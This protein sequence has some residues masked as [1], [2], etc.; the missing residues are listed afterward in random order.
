[1][2]NIFILGANGFIGSHLL[3]SLLKNTDHKI[4]TFDMGDH[5]IEGNLDHPNLTFKQGNI[6]DHKDWM[7]DQ[8]KAC[9]IVLPLIAIANPELYVKNPL[10]VF[11]LDFE[12]NLE[13]VKLCVEHKKRLIFPSTSEV[14]GMCQDE[15]FDEESSNLVLGPI[16]KQRWIYSCSKQMLDRVIYAHGIHSDLN[17][18]IF[19]PFNWVGPRLD[20]IDPEKASYARV[21]TQFISNIYYKGSLTLVDGGLQKRAFIDV[22]DAID[23][24]VRIIDNPEK[25][26]KEI[27]N[28]GYPSN[29]YSIKDLSDFVLEAMKNHDIFRDKVAA[30]NIDIQT[31][32]E[33]FGAHYQ[34]MQRRVPS[35][36]KAKDLL[37][38]A[39][40]LSLKDSVEK[41]VAYQA[42]YLK[43]KA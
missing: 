2:S 39:P 9:D 38:W 28:I 20:S 18:S 6:Y 26:N 33:R 4:V 21:I 34:D 31:S 14:Y 7:I 29:E 36:N 15:E 10:G 37:D 23:A 19:R 11:E 16:N 27:I 40:S 17:Y 42:D 13:I 22:S 24:L 8:I 12:L 3:D 43:K 41:I 1:M 30:A 32:E 25:T 35:I 5:N